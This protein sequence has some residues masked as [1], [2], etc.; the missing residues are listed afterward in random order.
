MQYK[1]AE[2]EGALL[3]AVVAK[4]EGFPFR[5][6]GPNTSLPQGL[7]NALREIEGEADWGAWAP[8]E[9]WDHGGPIIQRE[10]IV[11]EPRASVD[12]LPENSMIGAAAKA[13]HQ[14][15]LPEPAWAERSWEWQTGPTYLIA[16]MRAYVASKYGE[17]VELP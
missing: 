8:S 6:F 12:G 17:T 11:I 7:C 13:G 14:Y 10:L 15:V 3:D 9:I 4:A 5:L 2:L 1:V 16:A